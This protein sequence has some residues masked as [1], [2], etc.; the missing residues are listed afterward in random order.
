MTKVLIVGAGT[1]GSVHTEA[2]RNIPEVSWIGIAD[3]DLERARELAALCEGE[4]F[5]SMEEAAERHADLDVIDICLP[6]HLH[7]EITIRA[8]GHA[9][10]VICEKPLAGNP[11]DAREMIHICRDR[12]VRLFVAHVVRFFP[13]YRMAKQ[14][15]QQGAFG[16]VGMARCSRV[17][18]FPAGW[19]DW[20]KDRNRSGGL[21]LDLMIH[22]L[23]FLR[24][25]FGEPERVFAQM[26]PP[27]ADRDYG[28]AT[29]R[30]RNGTIAHVESSWAH[31]EFVTSYEF[32]GKA[33]VLEHDSAREVPLVVRTCSAEHERP[34]VAVPQSPLA[35]GAYE[36]ELRHFLHCLATG[37]EPLVTAE[38]GLK[39]VEMACAVN[40]SAATG[41]PIYLSE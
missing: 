14:R 29:V 10:A 26:T 17:G 20:Y 9:R 40:R 35:V 39:A 18:P 2:Y 15:L 16:E 6:T 19:N 22:D 32:A 25:C 1:M 37:E 34:G 24:W 41:Q 23:D 7:K 28:L 12:G 27:E 38:D 13:A 21:A 33:G 5:S 3:S 36:A 11:E 31:D 4:A 30:F 8:A